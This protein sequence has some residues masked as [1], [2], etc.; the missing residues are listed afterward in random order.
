MEPISAALIL[1]G[2]VAS[3][4]AA[5]Y[6]NKKNIEYASQ[7]NDT[8]IDLA[9]T[10]H[11]REVRD[12]R[13]AGLN[14]ILSASGSGAA[15]P[16]LRVPDLQNPLSE[17]GT[18]ARDLASSLNGAVDA[19][20]S[21]AKSEAAT[22]KEVKELTAREN[23]YD[24]L[25]KERQALEDAAFISAMD[26]DNVVRGYKDDN[27]NDAFHYGNE[28]WNRL[29]NQFKRSIE[30]GEYESQWS[31]SMIKDVIGNAGDAAGVLNPISNSLMNG[32]KAIKLLRSMK[33]V[34]LK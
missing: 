31:R 7:A 9:N 10:A 27:L 29:R 4:A 21:L 17:A 6:T 25:S 12:L 1:A 34:K 24:R 30:K 5:V 15:V 26:D 16:Q 14:P 18:S 3:S 8:Q 19:N 2:L 33:G 28:T 22:A 11:Q 32:A 13:A 20:L 23:A